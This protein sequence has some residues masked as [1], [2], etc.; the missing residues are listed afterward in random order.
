MLVGFIHGVMN[1]DNMAVS[2]ETI[3]YGPCAFMD[4]YDP[5]AVFSSI[6]HAGRYAFGNQPTVAVWNLAR[7]AETLLPLLGNEND[8]QAVADA[9]AILETFMPTFQNHW[10]NGARNKMGLAHGETGANASEAE[11]SLIDDWFELL[12]KYKVD[13]T[14]GWRYLADAAEGNPCNLRSL[15][16]TSTDVDNFLERWRGLQDDLPSSN[17]ATKMRAT[18]PIYIPRNHLVEE[19][20]SAASDDGNLKPFEIL[21]QAI[22]RPFTED[23]T[24]PQYALPASAEFTA[25]YRTFCGT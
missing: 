4:A 24:L 6:D 15:F 21:L 2:G 19:A 1:T 7:F 11:R 17:V 12:A 9:T 14:L 23:P 5:N 13:Y 8:E 10:Y 16:T 25:N 3:D 18:N 22:R 20:L